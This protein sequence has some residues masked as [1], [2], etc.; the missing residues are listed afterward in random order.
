MIWLSVIWYFMTIIFRCDKTSTCDQ[1]QDA[2]CAYRIFEDILNV[3]LQM[4]MSST[5]HLICIPFLKHRRSTTLYNSGIQL[6]GINQGPAFAWIPP[7]SGDAACPYHRV[8]CAN[9]RTTNLWHFENR[10]TS[11]DE[12]CYLN[13]NDISIRFLPAWRLKKLKFEIYN[14]IQCRS[15]NISILQCIM[16]KL[17]LL[18]M[19]KDI[20]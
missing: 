19:A 14:V 5:S 8:S 20:V 11:R 10:Y 17:V 18:N 1:L 6:V 12:V 9:I 3:F 7:I 13:G 4:I 16:S 15:R 2:L